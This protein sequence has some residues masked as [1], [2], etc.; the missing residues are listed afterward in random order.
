MEAKEP[1]HDSKCDCGTCSETKE[2]L[3][4]HAESCSTLC[5]GHL[6]PSSTIVSSAVAY[7]LAIDLGSN[8]KLSALRHIIL[9]LHH[10]VN[11]SP[12]NIHIMTDMTQSNSIHGFGSSPFPCVPARWKCIHMDCESNIA[13]SS[14]LSPSTQSPYSVRPRHT[15]AIPS[16]KQY[17]VLR[18]ILA[19]TL[20]TPAK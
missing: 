6:G 9:G 19:C 7:F 16:S 12:S 17:F 10:E 4:Y 1:L 5:P 20:S 3:N 15:E 8:H 13:A 2:Q 14:A 18:Y 11:S